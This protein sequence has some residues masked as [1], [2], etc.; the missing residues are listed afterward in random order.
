MNSIHIGID[1]IL[2]EIGGAEVSWHGLLMVLGIAIGIGLALY[3]AKHAEIS[4]EVIYT[5]MLWAIPLATV[6]AR[7]VHVLDNIE[8]YSHSPEKI[9]AV[10]E[11]GLSFYGGLLGGIVAVVIWA[12]VKGFSLGRFADLAAPCIILGLAIGRIGCVIN[13]DAAGTPTSLPWGLVYT[14]PGAYAPLWVAGHPAPI[15]EIIWDLMVFTALW[16]LQGRL[17][18][19][20]SLFLIFLALY[21][22]GRFL[23]SWVRLEPEVLGPLHQA[24][25]ISL[26]LFV[27]AIALLVRQ[28]VSWV[29]G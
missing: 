4:R 29:K 26:V 25:I 7:L 16:R 8:Y 2:A 20:G 11:G 3:R 14:H 10:W 17:K 5:A 12:R 1:P 9:I 19:D 28:K 6:G 23:I 15:Y 24:H 27:V 18:P 21:S 22:F 13:G